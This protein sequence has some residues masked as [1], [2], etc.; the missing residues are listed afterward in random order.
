MTHE[1]TLH[2]SVLALRTERAAV[3]S[4]SETQVPD[5]ALQERVGLH[6]KSNMQSQRCAAQA[7]AMSLQTYLSQ[8]LRLLCDVFLCIAFP[9]LLAL[10]DLYK[11]HLD[12]MCPAEV[13][14]FEASPDPAPHRE[15]LVPRQTAAVPKLVR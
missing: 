2:V 13:Y 10:H 7:R 1:G 15:H 5:D 3:L 11:R 8:D 6:R 14:I 12:L 4:F 9:L